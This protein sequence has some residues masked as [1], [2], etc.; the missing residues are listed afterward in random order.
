VTEANRLRNTQPQQVLPSTVVSNGLE[1]GQPAPGFN[2]LTL[3]GGQFATQQF[4]GKYV[5]L[6]FW[7][8][9]C[10]PCRGEIPYLQDVY[11]TYG[12]DKRFVLISLSID[13]QIQTPAQY[14]VQ[15]QMTWLQGFLG[16]NS[17]VVN[18]MYQVRSIPSIMLIGPDGKVIAAHLRG[19]NIKKKVA[20]VLS[21]K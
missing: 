16:A 19:D 15:N 3:D 14:A 17:P 20:E 21:A 9:W 12:K 1:A 6:D 2:A 4:K 8:T 10:G 18:K 5:L 11:Q 7:A 13:S